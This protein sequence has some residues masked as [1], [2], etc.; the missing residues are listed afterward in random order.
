MHRKNETATNLNVQF[1]LT[2]ST[3]DTVCTDFARTISSISFIKRMPQQNVRLFILIV[4]ILF[5]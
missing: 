4:V 5:V 1:F 2:N 3:N